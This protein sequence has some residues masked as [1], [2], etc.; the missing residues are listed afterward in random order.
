[1]DQ[2]PPEARAA[3]EAALAKGVPVK[4]AAQQIVVNGQQFASADELPASERKLYDDA[5]SLVRDNTTIA[6]APASSS[7][8]L[9]PSQLRLAVLLTAFAVFVVWMVRLLG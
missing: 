6:K 9:T 1:V 3:Y 2:L 8:W 4:P 5:L 7:S